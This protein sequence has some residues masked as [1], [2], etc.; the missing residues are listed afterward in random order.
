MWSN[1]FEKTTTNIPTK[2]GDETTH[3]KPYVNISLGFCAISAARFC[4]LPS[5]H[6]IFQGY[7]VT[8]PAQARLCFT[9][10]FRTFRR[11]I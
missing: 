10:Y 4:Y 7:L 8:V 3:L 2:P 1:L 6:P 9:F 5:V 11:N